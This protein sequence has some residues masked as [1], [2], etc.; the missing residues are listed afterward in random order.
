MM[1]V[2]AYVC[3]FWLAGIELAGQQNSPPELQ[4]LLKGF[5]ERLIQSY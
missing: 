2:N 1:Q 4:A 5:L 3:Q